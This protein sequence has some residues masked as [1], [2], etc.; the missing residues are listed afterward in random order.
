VTETVSHELQQHPE[1]RKGSP[2]NQQKQ[3]QEKHT[4]TKK[5]RITRSGHETIGKAKGGEEER[6]D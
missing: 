4:K 6:E 3:R 2:E 5:D 1:T